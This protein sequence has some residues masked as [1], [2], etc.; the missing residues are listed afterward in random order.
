MTSQPSRRSLLKAAV[1]V[2][3]GAAVLPA[4]PGSAGAAVL[5]A[6]ALKHPGMLHTQADFDRMRAQVN[7]GAQPWKAGWDRLVAN[8]RSKSTWKPRP[9]ET[10]IRGGTG[11][12][13]VQASIDIAAAY[14]NALRWKISGEKAHGDTA[15]DILNAWS[16]TLKTL[17][18]NADRY[19]AAGI[20]GWQFAN[21]AEIM[22]GYP[23]FDLER[24]KRMLLTVFYPMND[25]FLKEHNGA[26]ISNYWANW[27]LCTMNSI[28][29]IGILCDDQ[30]KIEQAVDYFRN[31]KGNGSIMNAV[32][33]LHENGTLGQW[34][35]SG[36]D[37]GHSAV[38]VGWM[39]VF[40]ETAWNQ[41][42]DLYGYAGNRFMKGAEYVARYNLGETVPF[43]TYKWKNGTTCASREQTV[44][45]A[46]GRGH[47]DP[48][49]AM[50]YN[51]YGVRRGLD[52]PGI[53]AFSK[54]VA[55]EGGGGDYGGSQYDHLGFGTLTFTRATAGDGGGLLATGVSR[56][57]ESV[58][59]PKAY[60]T[61][62]G[63]LGSDALTLRVVPGLADPKGYSLV[64]AEGR[65]LRHKNFLIRFDANDGT[66]LFK[67]DV[68]FHARRGTVVGSVRLESVNYP[69]RFVRHR[70]DRLRLD[71]AEDTALFRADSSFRP[72]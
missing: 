5:P 37:Q 21:A 69:G 31:G 19:L 62:S 28:L 15:R 52:V 48:I 11:Q 26:C 63:G 70:G 25:R 44:I 18:G 61:E 41:G 68:T 71:K 32:P 38:G 4:L 2:G 49:W 56:T 1:T 24:F 64:D 54:K 14:Q 27:D 58:N 20:Q 47:V 40:C 42:I 22:R 45:S 46:A 66:A 9:L 34:Q 36:R 43:T 23:G 6:A 10:V 59:D 29:A 13:N 55:P 35:E 16:G 12:N 53:E 30:A 3:A 50:I 67:R 65:Y 39:G 17:T 7:A 60:I 72:A 51:H 33:F 8:G 57:F